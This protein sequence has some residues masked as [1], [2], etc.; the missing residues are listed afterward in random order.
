MDQV[1][2]CARYKLVYL[3]QKADEKFKRIINWHIQTLFEHG[4]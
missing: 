4:N 3:L 1:P 2:P